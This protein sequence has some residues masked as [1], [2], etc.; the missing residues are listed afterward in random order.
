MTEPVTI[1][2]WQQNMCTGA[3]LPMWEGEVPALKDILKMLPFV[4]ALLEERAALQMSG[5][6]QRKPNS[7]PEM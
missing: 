4:S 6:S 5:S 2:A 1:V 7:W 3:C